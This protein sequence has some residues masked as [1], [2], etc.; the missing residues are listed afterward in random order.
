MFC[1][2]VFVCLLFVFYQRLKPGERGVSSCLNCFSV[3]ILDRKTRMVCNFSTRQ[4]LSIAA[5]Q[6]RLEIAASQAEEE[7]DVSD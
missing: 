3:L 5:I 6:T 7:S 4:A 2:F 1:S